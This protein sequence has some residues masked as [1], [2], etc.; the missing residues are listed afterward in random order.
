MTASLCP[1]IGQVDG[2]D[3]VYFGF[4]YHGNGVSTAT[5]SGQQL[6]KW[7]GD[8]RVPV[9]LPAIVRGLNKRYPLPALR[10]TYLRFA[11]FVARQLDRYG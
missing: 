11:I 10:Q 2:D 6:A 9:T 4:G 1:S 7:I 5:W 3:D 8:G